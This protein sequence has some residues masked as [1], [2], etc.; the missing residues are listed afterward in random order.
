MMVLKDS[1]MLSLSNKNRFPPFCEGWKTICCDVHLSVCFLQNQTAA[2][3][4]RVTKEGCFA[5]VPKS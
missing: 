3:K 1:R 2:Q 5:V 4:E